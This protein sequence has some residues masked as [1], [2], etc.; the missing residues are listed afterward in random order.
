[1][2][3]TP[4]R[5]WHALPDGRIQCELCPRDCKLHDGQRGAC[6]VRA[7]QAG[8]MIL[9]TYGRS[10]GFCIDPIEKKPLN[11]FY[12]GSSVLSFGT[13]GC[14]LACK[15]CQNW[16][17][18]KSREMDTL[19]DDAM[20]DAIARAA[21]RYHSH[22]VAFTYNDPVIFAE[23]AMDTADACHALGIKAVAVTAGYMHLPAAREFYARMD[24]ANVDL[25][26]FTDDF[27]FKLCVGHL[28]PV[29]DILAYIHHETDCWLEITT[30]LIPGQNDSDQELKELSAWCA[31]ELGP[32]V[33]LHFSAFHPDYR[34]TDILATPPDTLRHA[35]Q[36]AIDAGL[37]YVYTGNIHNR[38]GDTTWCPGCGKPVIERDWY[39]ILNYQ[40]DDTAST[41]RPPLPAATRSSTSPSAPGA[42]PCG[43]TGPDRKERRLASGRQVGHHIALQMQC[44]GIAHE[45]RRHS[46][47]PRLPGVARG[48]RKPAA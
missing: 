2:S 16:D 30:L 12:P 43:C 21:Q 3:G 41:A 39:E 34:M 35:R 1:L 18:S 13:A 19:M 4:A 44:K 15:F 32:D 10:S 27:Y 31:R 25:K 37:R 8:Q 20:P 45:D 26:A 17:I 23:Y 11:H 7:N 47:R 42:S 38:G 29:L 46:R 5:W 33:P 22:S 28:Q 36:I 24:A 14:N 40:L 9:T 6:F 48:C